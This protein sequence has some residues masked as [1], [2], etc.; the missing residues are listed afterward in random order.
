L[1]KPILKPFAKGKT[2]R[3]NRKNVSR[4]TFGNR[5]RF[6]TRQKFVGNISIL[7][8]LMQAAPASI[9]HERS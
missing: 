8:A 6:C 7:Q 1:Y 9:G 5:F 3:K 2:K 4:E